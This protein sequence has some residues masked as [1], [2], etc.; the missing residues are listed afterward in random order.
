MSISSSSSSSGQSKEADKRSVRGSKKAH[1]HCHGQGLREGDM[2]AKQ[3]ADIT[4]L[5]P[6]SDLAKPF[7]T[8]QAV[9][10]AHKLNLTS[11][12]PQC[13]HRFPK[14][15]GDMDKIPCPGTASKA[16]FKSAISQK[17]THQSQNLKEEQ[18]LWLSFWGVHLHQRNHH[19]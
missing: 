8:G 6:S 5:Q 4:A 17:I 15:I 9:F 14:Y 7:K 2:A 18:L 19:H 12:T 11:G 10:G 1:K 16:R 13:G 3:Q